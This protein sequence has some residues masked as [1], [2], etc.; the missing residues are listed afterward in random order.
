MV[1]AVQTSAQHEVR[2]SWPAQETLQHDQGRLCDRQE[3]GHGQRGFRFQGERTAVRARE[4]ARSSQRTSQASW[5]PHRVETKDGGG[6]LGSCPSGLQRVLVS[7]AIALADPA[8]AQGCYEPSRCALTAR[9]VCSNAPPIARSHPAARYARAN[10][11]RFQ[12]MPRTPAFRLGRS[13]TGLGLFATA[14]I[15]RRAFI[16]EYKGRK[17]TT[18]QADVLEA[19][20]N[21]YLYEI[22]S[23]WTIDGTTRRN[24]GRYANHSCRPNA[25]SHRIGHKV[26]L[27]AIK[28]IK[29]G[30]EITYSYGRDYFINV[31]MPRGCKCD[32][33]RAK[34]AAA[35]AKTRAKARAKGRAKTRAKTRAK[36][37][38]KA[39]A[40]A[41]AGKRRT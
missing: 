23:R 32:K 18:A 29:P 36:S 14:P 12:R 1:R 22:N 38:V 5:V 31:I 15:K 7:A 41:R 2:S 35:Q 13:R 28:I 20:G 37:R 34:R 27:R 16:V 10:H 25:E 9:V 19:R 30:D 3:E 4:S 17:L 21:R 11:C 40:K 33:C 39:G 24:L 8:H 6:C 26:I